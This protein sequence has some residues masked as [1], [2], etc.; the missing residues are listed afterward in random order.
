MTSFFEKQTSFSHK[1]WSIIAYKYMA[2]T[3][4]RIS[5]IHDF[6]QTTWLNLSAAANP[7]VVDSIA[8]EA[9]AW[10]RIGQPHWQ[11]LLAVCQLRARR[12]IWWS[13]QAE[14]TLI[15]QVCAFHELQIAHPLQASICLRSWL[16]DTQHSDLIELTHNYSTK[17]LFLEEVYCFKSICCCSVWQACILHTSFDNLLIVRI[18]KSS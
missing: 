8:W 2:L 4:K 13:Q 3:R 6:F 9:L 16:A 15:S 17:T 1:S 12:S 10:S 18:W 5:T 14:E 7:A 11:W